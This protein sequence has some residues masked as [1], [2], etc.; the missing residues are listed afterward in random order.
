MIFN[1]CSN[2]YSKRKPIT[3]VC[4]LFHY[5]IDLSVGFCFLTFKQNLPI[6]NLKQFFQTST[7]QGE[8]R[9]PNFLCAIL[10]DISST[11]SCPPSF[12]S[13]LNMSNSF[14]HFFRIVSSP[15]IILLY[16]SLSESLK[17]DIRKWKQEMVSN[18]IPVTENY[19]SVNTT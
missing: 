14:S 15:L 11:L 10:F 8:E 5:Q 7:L 19:K 2:I 3:S 9:S 1:P 6:Y 12:F 17:C 4:N 18:Q 13:K 16:S